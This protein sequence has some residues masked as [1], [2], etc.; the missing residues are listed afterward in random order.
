MIHNNLFRFNV[1]STAAFVIFSI[2][3]SQVKADFYVINDAFQCAK[4]GEYKNSQELTNEIA[5]LGL[6]TKFGI[7]CFDY[8]IDE[9]SE[10]IL[11]IYQSAQDGAV[12]NEKDFSTKID[13]TV[14]AFFF[15]R[16]IS[17][18]HKKPIQIKKVDEIF[19]KNLS[20]REKESI[21]QEEF[22]D[23]I[24][25]K[26][27]SFSKL[28]QANLKRRSDENNKSCIG[29]LLPHQG[30]YEGGIDGDFGEN[31]EKAL[32]KFIEFCKET[33]ITADMITGTLL[34]QLFAFAEEPAEGSDVN[35]PPE[36]N[37]P[38]DEKDIKQA[39]K[40]SLAGEPSGAEIENEIVELEQ[41]L[42]E[43]RS[44]ISSLEQ[45]K[46]D[47]QKANNDVVDQKNAAKQTL[48][49]YSKKPIF[50]LWEELG[51]KVLGE[52]PDGTT[53]VEALKIEVKD[54]CKISADKSL[55]KSAEI[56]YTLPPYRSCF[57]FSFKDS[58]VDPDQSPSWDPNTKEIIVPI[59][60]IIKT[61]TSITTDKI[62]D[63][64]SNDI[65]DCAVQLSFLKNGKTIHSFPPGESGG[66]FPLWDEVE[67]AGAYL[68]ATEILDGT[69][70]YDGLSVVVET[71]DE[72]YQ[73]C[74]LE[75]EVDVPIRSS[76]YR[77]TGSA[78]ALVDNDGN[79]TL[80]DLPITVVK[81]ATLAVFYDTNVGYEG[82]IQYAFNQSLNST[83]MAELQRVYL[84]GF[85][86]ALKSYLKEQTAFESII[87]Y[88]SLSA[89][90]A[91]SGSKTTDFKMLAKANNIQDPGAKEM[92]NGILDSF[93]NNFI[94]GQKGSYANKKR[95][96][97]DILGTNSP[98]KFLIFGS[99]GLEA[100]AVCD[101]NKRSF[102]SNLTTFDVWSL[103]T[104]EKLIIS[105]DIDNKPKQIYNC[106]GSDKLFGLKQT[107]GADQ[108]DVS[109]P[110]LTYLKTYL[111]D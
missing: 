13:N 110:V 39:L 52:M 75:S 77:W 101:R 82:E 38:P 49:D 25:N 87:I 27:P 48:K 1:V 108:N 76:K 22:L 105:G 64:E 95:E 26:N 12:I 21:T 90:E 109:Y 78:Q 2:F 57:K 32:E 53:P 58:I 47:L 100:S 97:K 35:R 16:A 33:E 8:S 9:A 24:Y 4:N 92:I 74:N 56:A 18:E 65:G 81:G 29:N 91:T 88:Q 93:K 45:E 68:Q 40:E 43:A 99:S 10:K 46:S 103:P 67:G 42:K 98:V 72:T 15:S 80:H 7:A 37:P 106:N 102:D 66:L 71:P 30:F 31:S 96:I 55:M 44:K 34:P 17:S 63:L 11:L 73:K 59:L 104:L 69:I 3:S 107:F 5:L 20:L 89:S 60:R 50:E 111:K 19:P 84:L 70:F 23:L 62:A 28:I 83:K 79:I 61:I 41:K 51:I 94:P 14:R 85:T 86:D 36:Q 6:P 54:D